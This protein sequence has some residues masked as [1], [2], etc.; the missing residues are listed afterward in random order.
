MG[1]FGPSLGP[2]LV[3]SGGLRPARAGANRQVNPDQLDFDEL[4]VGLSIDG[5]VFVEL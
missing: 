4:G 2:Q 5:G 3:F 1:W